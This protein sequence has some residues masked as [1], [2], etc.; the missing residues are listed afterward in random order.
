MKSNSFFT[1]LTCFLFFALPVILSPYVVCGAPPSEKTAESEKIAGRDLVF[2]LTPEFRQKV[3]EFKISPFEAALILFRDSNLG[4]TSAKKLKGISSYGTLR[5]I[6]GNDYVFSTMPYLY[7]KGMP[8]DG[9]YVDGFTGE[10]RVILYSPNHP[11]KYPDIPDFGLFYFSDPLL[12]VSSE[13]EW[14]KIVESVCPDVP[15]NARL[16][17]AKKQ[18]EGIQSIQK[19][20]QS[21]ERS[22]P[23]LTEL[24][25]SLSEVGE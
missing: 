18:F 20:L 2:L 5:C 10:Y 6:K 1:S 19:M 12:T 8:M 7:S 22:R 15:E 16:K 11:E 9:T 25:Q 17:W 23:E 21:L 14:Q 3:S 13:R 4:V 24:M